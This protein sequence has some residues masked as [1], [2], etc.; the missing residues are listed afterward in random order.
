MNETKK[1]KILVVDDEPNVRR[2][3]ATIL[4]REGYDVAEAADGPEGVAVAVRE[5]PDLV[6]MDLEMP[7]MNGF[8]AAELIKQEPGLEEVR[9]IAITA[10]DVLSGP[11]E[12]FAGFVAKPIPREV[13]LGEVERLNPFRRH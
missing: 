7:Y 1:L 13:L 11:A 2:I 12:L 5:R 3:L 10:H 6:L 4:R 8:Q 9:I